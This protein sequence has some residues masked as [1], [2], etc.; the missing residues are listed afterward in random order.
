VSV[1]FYR[2]VHGLGFTPWERLADLP[3]ARQ[4]AALFDREEE[5]RQ[6]PYG[7]ALD[8][9]CGT[10]GWSVTLASRGWQVTGI[11]VVAKAVRAAQEQARE[12]GVEARFIHGDVANINAADVGSG[13]RLVLDCGTVHGLTPEQREAVGRGVNAVT[14]PDATL[15]MY[16]YAPKSR[17]P[18]PRGASRAEIEATYPGWRVT[19]EIP[20]DPT[21]LPAGAQQDDP[22]W[23]RLQRS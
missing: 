11:D 18:L 23:Y 10:G 14:A 21:G 13:F 22:R 8:L 19:D 15:L 7:L 17:G 5:G 1:L 3:A 20:F 9:G 4:L 16:A 6:A 2:A 12:A